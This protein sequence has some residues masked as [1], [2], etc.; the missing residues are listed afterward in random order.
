M[1]DQHLVRSHVTQHVHQV[2]PVIP[3]LE[4]DV[5]HLAVD[6]HVHRLD[7]ALRRLTHLQHL[8]GV[9][10]LLELRNVRLL[11]DLRL[12]L[13]L[14]VIHVLPRVNRLPVLVERT[15]HLCCR[16]HPFGDHQL[17]HLLLVLLI[18]L[19]LHLLYPTAEPSV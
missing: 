9:H 13:Q 5:P 19:H 10:I 7:R 16:E 3:P 18:T 15:A 4:V 14:L 6:A 8:G 12:Q 2:V 17:G 11:L 1:H